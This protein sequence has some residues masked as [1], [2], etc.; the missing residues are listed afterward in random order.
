MMVRGYMMLNTNLVF[1]ALFEIRKI[2]CFY[3]QDV[4]SVTVD[5]LML[6]W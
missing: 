3:T 1:G 2:M 4:A 6:P 5:A